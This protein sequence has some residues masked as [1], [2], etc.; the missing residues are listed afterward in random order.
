MIV[1][2]PVAQ[3]RREQQRGVAVNRN[4][5]GRHAFKDAAAKKKFPQ[6]TGIFKSDRLLAL[7]SDGTVVGWGDNSYGQTNIPSGLSGVA[8]IAAGYGYSLAVKSN[9]TFVAW[10]L[11]NYGLVTTVPVGL[12]NVTAVAVTY[13]HGLA[14]KS[15]GT[16]V[17]WGYNGYGQT[18]VPAGLTGVSAIAAQNSQSLALKRKAP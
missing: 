6:K 7:K 4:K 5:A 11:D 13:T 3:I 12:S 10:G 2:H 15:D 9:G 17:G 18:N 16:V 8:L 1:R 14:L